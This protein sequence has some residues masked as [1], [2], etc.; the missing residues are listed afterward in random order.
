MAIHVSIEGYDSLEQIGVGGMAAVYK[1]RKISVD[2]VVAIKVLFPYLAN[3]ESFIERF[4]REAK[5]AARIQ[6]EN[7]VNVIDF[8][9]SEDAYYIVMEYYDGQTLEDILKTRSE[10]PL[11]IV[12][13]V[14][15]E[16]CYG[17]ESAHSQ[18]TVHRDIKPG[19]II[20][21]NQGG[22]KIAD[23]GLAKKSDSMTMITQHGKVIGTP[24]YMSP[25]QA[26]GKNVGPQSDVFSLGVVA[27]EILGMK[28][29]FEGKTY[30]EVLEKIQTYEP[31]SVADVNPLIQQDFE[32]I[33]SKM[34]EKD[35]DKRYA[36]IGEVITDIEKAMEK[37][38][39]TRDRRRL[40]SYISDPDAYEAAY[41][42]KIINRCLSQGAFYMK[43]GQSHL[44]EAVLEF[45]RILY[46]DPDNERAKRNLERIN[47]KR[48]KDQTVTM[49]APDVP[50]DSKSGE[51]KASDADTKKSKRHKSV[52]V[53]AASRNAPRSRRAG[54]VIAGVAAAAVLAAGWFGHQRGLI[55]LDIIG[56]SANRPPALSAPGH[57]T[58][59]GGE[60]L[61][62]VLQ[63]VDAEGDSVR[64][65]TDGLPRGATLTEAGEFEWRV[66]YDQTG[67]HRIKFYADDG[68]SASLS[69]TEVEVQ[70]VKLTL[71]FQRIGTLHVDAGKTLER[72]LRAKSS[73]G[74][75]VKYTL[76]G[77][78]KGVRI[79]HG[80]LVW[81]PDREVSGTFD[82]VIEASD[83]AATREQMVTLEVRSVAEQEAE[84]ARV[85]WTLPERANVYVDDDL[86]ESETR[87]LV[88]ELPKGKHTLR[89]DLMDGT[90]AWIETLDL[91]PG[92]NVQ[93][94]APKLSFGSL[95]V[96][97]LG[98]VGEFRVDGKLFR[99]QPPFSRESIPVGKHSVSCRM[100]NE[101][102]AKELTISVEKSRETIIEYEV[103]GEPVVSY[104]P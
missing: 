93:L 70:A 20:F 29:P 97:F 24:A 21:T 77:A 49:V 7:I 72:S 90:T 46:L 53:V 33:V 3:D 45:K 60:R 48:G 50:D 81:Q 36:T 17:L 94:K 12:V 25:E 62:F 19:N 67:K 35:L 69:E 57:I 78:P 51:A 92:E 89:A 66:G 40:V 11:D 41:K 101:A 104:E 14:L 30:S 6:H 59:T 39:I 13:Q 68:T 34:L 31:L 64:F 37:F 26:A 98:G 95:S 56:K 61:E 2:K 71:D 86:K 76:K 99:A 100:A 91:K 8:G 96:Y 79:E 23:F 58:V 38:R 73:S 80:K 42:K 27:Y 102:R 18:D 43:K 87:R 74:R 75:P 85:D 47:A 16:V 4:Q 28:K 44:D 84:L 63:A 83:G 88:V 5:A 65:Y 32:N 1:A 10:L 55:P 103:G 15:L 82:A 54:W 9:Q 52:T 22:I